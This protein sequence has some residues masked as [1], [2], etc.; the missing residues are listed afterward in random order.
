MRN[1]TPPQIDLTEEMVKALEELG[2][3]VDKDHLCN[4]CLHR[5]KTSMGYVG[6]LRIVLYE[7]PACEH[8]DMREF[9]G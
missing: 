3:E 2:K 7:C 9:I 4:R 1:N 6:G 8:V 5:M